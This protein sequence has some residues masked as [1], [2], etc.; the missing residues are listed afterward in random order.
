[1][2]R[3]LSSGGLASSYLANGLQEKM[4][5]TVESESRII[6]VEK[7]AIKAAVKDERRVERAGR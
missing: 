2:P 6:K 3:G 7:D 4:Q 1:V 5:E